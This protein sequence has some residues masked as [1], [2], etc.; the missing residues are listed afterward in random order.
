TPLGHY[1]D[2]TIRGKELL[3]S[4]DFVIGEEFRPTSTLLKKIGLE[5]KEIY[6]LNEHTRDKDLIELVEL[7]RQHKVAFVSD[8]GTPNF[9]DPGFQ[10]IARLR[11][12]KIPVQALPGPSSLALIISLSSEKIESFVFVGFLPAEREKRSARLK[13]LATEKRSIVLME[14]PYRIGKLLAELAEVMP[15]RRALLGLDLTLET[16]QV[17]EAS[18]KK[19]SEMFSTSTKAE[20]ILLIY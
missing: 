11:R 5:Q 2:I 1:G 14:T 6:E 13:N 12:E 9:C 17:E 16:E 3:A 10:L 18:I 19:L 20:P 4:C 8:C 7:C 15:S